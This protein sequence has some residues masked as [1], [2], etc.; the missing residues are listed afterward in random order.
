MFK[1]Q[2][3][4]TNNNKKENSEEIRKCDVRII[5]FEF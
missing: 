2:N 5:L 4:V 3:Y 1:A